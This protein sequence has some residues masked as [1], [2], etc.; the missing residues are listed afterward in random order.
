MNIM[1]I[2]VALIRNAAREILLVRKQGTQAFMQPGGKVQQ[3]ETAQ[4]ALCRELEEELA[5]TV[6]PAQLK[7]LAHASALAANEADTMVEADIFAIEGDEGGNGDAHHHVQA[8]IAEAVWVDPAR[9]IS[10]CLAPLTRD[11]IL[12]LACALT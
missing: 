4:D 10:L 8:E 3:G 2:A 7:W 11:H 5:M 1:P 9:P 6:R 12:P